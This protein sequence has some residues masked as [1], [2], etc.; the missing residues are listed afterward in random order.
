MIIQTFVESL[1]WDEFISHTFWF[2]MHYLLSNMGIEIFLFMLHCVF[3]LTIFMISQEC[4]L[5]D[6]K[7]NFQPPT[8]CPLEMKG[9]F[10]LILSQ[11]KDNVNF[12]LLSLQCLS[13]CLI[14]IFNEN[15]K[16]EQLWEIIL[17]VKNHIT[18][19]DPPKN[20]LFWKFLN[21]S[22]FS[23]IFKK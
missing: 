2:T 7:V 20:L 18:P 1:N 6:T 9:I 14:F 16:Q 8:S 19:S 22:I 21:F 17:E 4:T 11:L 3:S 23:G 15:S 12:V 13:V 10:W 5:T